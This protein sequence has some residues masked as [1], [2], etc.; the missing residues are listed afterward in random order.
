MI[1]SCGQTSS[2][3]FLTGIWLVSKEEAEVA[4]QDRT[5]WRILTSQAASADM[6]DADW[7][8]YVKKTT[9]T[10]TTTTTNYF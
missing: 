9:T 2:E 10:T 4:A 5:V 3:I 8:W 1:K 6:H 7:W